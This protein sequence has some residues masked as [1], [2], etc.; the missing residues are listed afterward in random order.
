MGESIPIV[1][2]V[3]LSLFLIYSSIS[4]CDAA[5]APMAK[6]SL[7]PHSVI[8]LWTRM[9]SVAKD[10]ASAYFESRQLNFYPHLSTAIM[11]PFHILT[12][13][14]KDMI[15]FYDMKSFTEMMSLSHIQ[16]IFFGFPRR[17]FDYWE[18]FIEMEADCIFRSVCDLSA[19][20][21]PRVPDWFNQM[22]GL[23]FTTYSDASHYFSAM[24][25]GMI[26][27]NC[28]HHYP[29]CSPSLMFN[30]TAMKN[31]VRQYTTTQA[32]III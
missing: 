6:R 3:S 31:V 32:P 16:D 23:Y 29:L 10:L 27:K 18:M 26:N 1:I 25:N 28:S 8:E 19:F 17:V 4:H 14:V 9:G 5:L 7:T 11:A 21:F 15:D 24:A 20:I 13:I 2:V 30:S 22:A 12:Q